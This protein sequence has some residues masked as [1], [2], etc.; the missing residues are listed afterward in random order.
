MADTPA[1]PRLLMVDDEPALRKIMAR[2]LQVAGFTVLEAATG[3]EGL[4]LAG[5]ERPD[6]ILLDLMLPEMNGFDVCLA[7]KQDPA[8][9]EIPV[10]IFT[11]RGRG[12]D[13]ERRCRALG[14]AAYFCKTDPSKEIVAALRKLLNLAA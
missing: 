1:G 2:L 14:A 5:S 12:S 9:R 7:L 3:K 8:T 11:A 6:A 10:V 4:A 13:D